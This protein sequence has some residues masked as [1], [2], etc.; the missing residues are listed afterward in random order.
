M[1][2]NKFLKKYSK[3]KLGKIERSICHEIGDELNFVDI[4]VGIL[5]S[6]GSSRQMFKSARAFHNWRSSRRRAI[7]SLQEKGIIKVKGDK[8]YLTEFGDAVI[9]IINTGR[10]T[11]DKNSR[12]LGK[13]WL[14]LAFDIPNSHNYLRNFLRDLLNNLDF[15]KIQQSLYVSPYEDKRFLDFLKRY[16]EIESYITFFYVD[17]K[18]APDSWAKKFNNLK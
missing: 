2:L 4:S 10:F 16:P 6:A 17:K 9:S 3:L 14:V 8:I 5:L 13:R 7:K 18:F 15:I 1:K 11:Q 12:K